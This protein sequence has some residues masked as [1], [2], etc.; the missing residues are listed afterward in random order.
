[1]KTTTS[2]SFTVLELLESNFPEG[3]KAKVC[4]DNSL[5]GT[6]VIKHNDSLVNERTGETLIL[7]SELLKS[8]FRLVNTEKEVGLLELLNAYK[9]GK[10]VKIQIDNHYR[11]IQKSNN[12]PEELK[13]LLE[14]I[15]SPVMKGK[16]MTADEVMTFQEL[17]E[18]KFYIVE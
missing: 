4:T 8:K 17:L 12:M 9:E 7:T 5:Y 3:Q 10:K 2:K 15:A 11:V 1:M 14:S 13:A 16:V 18:G 6:T